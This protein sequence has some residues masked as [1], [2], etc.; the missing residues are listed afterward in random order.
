VKY[1]KVVKGSH[2]IKNRE[3]TPE[4]APLPSDRD[5]TKIFPGKFV[6][7]S[8]PA[9]AAATDEAVVAR[10]DSQPP[11]PDQVSP[12]GVDVTAQFPEAAANDLKVFKKVSHH[13]VVDPDK[14]TAAL[15]AKA[16]KKDEVSAFIK[17]F[18]QPAAS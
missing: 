6:E 2:F 14:P 3:Y 8:A 5:L 18:V 16:L 4:S 9:V 7:V 15:N 12:F 10:L 17:K 13:Y 1:F 11:I